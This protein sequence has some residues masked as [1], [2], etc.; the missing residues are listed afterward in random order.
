M[1][2]VDLTGHFLIAMPAMTDPHF[3]KT[4]TYICEHNEQGALGV[5]VNRPIDMTLYALLRQI[6]I[7]KPA[8]AC[9]AMPVHFGGPVQ[10]DRGFV[11]HA[12]AGSWKSTLIVNEKIGLTTSKDILEAV[13]RGEGPREMLVTLGY[14]GWA[15]G[16]LERE[17]A[18]NAWLTVGADKHI[19]F[20][21]PAAQRY[22]AS[23]KL[24]GIDLAMLS[25]A[26]GHA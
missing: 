11:L 5:V 16:Q 22:D 14:A 4:L 1:Q 19:L 20:E 25:D 6:E 18:A 9:K 24:L 21:T 17:L 12:P 7:E 15:P 8:A 13:A 3:V 10:I 2:S 26:A 23:L